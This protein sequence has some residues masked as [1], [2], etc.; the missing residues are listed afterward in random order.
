MDKPLKSVT[1]D[2]RLPS[3]LQ[4]TTAS[5]SVPNILLCVRG[6]CVWITCPRLLLVTWKRKGRDSN[7]QSFESQVQRTNHYATRPG[8]KSGPALG[9]TEYRLMP[10]ACRLMLRVKLWNLQFQ[11]L[12]S[13]APM[14]RR[15]L[16]VVQC[17]L[18]LRSTFTTASTF[19]RLGLSQGI[20][21]KTSQCH[22]SAPWFRLGKPRRHHC[23]YVNS[24]SGQLSLLPS[25]AWKMF[26]PTS[27]GSAL[28]LGR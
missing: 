15:S 4:G 17:H 1:S 8:V 18:I 6:T 14:Q 16:V 24:Y 23:Q 19:G 21:W 20:N 3:Q 12:V 25:V 22:G 2:P 26:S 9:G 11:Y 27:S 10:S 7:R 13:R 5:W 28:Q